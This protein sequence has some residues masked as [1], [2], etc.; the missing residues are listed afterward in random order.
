MVISGLK[1]YAVEAKVIQ[2]MYIKH[3]TE[4]MNNTN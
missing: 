2:Y 1:L 4:E 3:T